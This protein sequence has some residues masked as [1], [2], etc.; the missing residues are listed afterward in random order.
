MSAPRI[1]GA[2]LFELT[3]ED[4][5]IT[6]APGDEGRPARLHYDGPLGEHVFEGDEIETLHSARGLEVRVTLDRIS[7]LR[8]VTLTVFLPELEF[9]DATSELTFRTVG[10]HS[11]RRR[12]MI[13]DSGE[14]ISEPLDFEGLARNGAG[15]AST[16][17]L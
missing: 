10:I 6:Y 7:S 2:T 11:T 3:T 17:V 1:D 8:T 5:S 4:S 9:E 12:G 15:G 13:S 14:I 16:A